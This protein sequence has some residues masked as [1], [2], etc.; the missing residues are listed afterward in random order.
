MLIYQLVFGQDY[1]QVQCA[2]HND[3]RASAGIGPNG[4]Y[5]CFACGTKAH[6]EVSF[7]CKYFGVGPDRARKIKFA[8]E[9][10]QQ[11]KYTKLPVD[12]AQEAYLKSVGI[13]DAV[14][15]KYFFKSR[16]G[17]LIYNHTWN[18][19]SVGYTWFNP[20]N[21]P[22][23]NASAGKYK[24]DKNNIG[25]ML[26]PYNDV[27]KYKKLII[28]EGEKDMLVAKSMGLPNAVAKIGGAKSYVLGGDN[29]SN[30]DIVICYDCDDAGREGAEQDATILTEKY[31][32]T[33][34][35][36]DLA[37]GKGEDLSD[38]F[39]KYN[40]SLQDFINLI[41]TTPVFVPK[42]KTKEDKFL[43]FIESLTEVELDELEKIIKNT[44]EKQNE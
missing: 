38:Y 26:T 39:V 40:H 7:I 6:D 15:K 4:E 36:V 32:S 37:L 16:V 31:A 20:T 12:Q 21:L 5:N 24:Y 28:C 14:I 13:S 43:N 33:V 29:V 10:I 3:T 11:Y 34:R 42:P 8:L 22:G 2:F 41:Q 30:K 18:G 44:K 17:K 35:V 1:G 25:G 23:Y 19:F 9:R 27:M